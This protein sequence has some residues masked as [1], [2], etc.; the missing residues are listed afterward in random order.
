MCL[1]ILLSCAIFVFGIFVSS[2]YFYHD[3]IKECE[4]TEKERV[5]PTTSEEKPRTPET[6]KWKENP[7]LFK[8]QYEQISEGIRSRDNITIVAG[9]IL[10]TGSL[11]LLG[12]CIQ[13][14]SQNI[15]GIETKMLMIFSSLAIYVIWLICFNL[16]S[17][18]MNNIGY[19]KLREME[20]DAGHINIHTQQLNKVRGKKW[21]EYL[22]RKLWP[23][24]LWVLIIVSIAILLIPT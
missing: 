9:T 17:K 23:W 21:W 4:T 19:S 16:T 22:R 11:L 6:P 3:R 14:V 15:V 24:L 20:K 5:K 12:I 7:G 10:I 18:E 8:L 1:V 13:L 2:Y